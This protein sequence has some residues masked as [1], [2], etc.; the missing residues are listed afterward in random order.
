[1]VHRENFE[2]KRKDFCSIRIPFNNEM[3]LCLEL[4]KTRNSKGMSYKG[5]KPL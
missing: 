1:M 3:E 4:L 2:A 5:F